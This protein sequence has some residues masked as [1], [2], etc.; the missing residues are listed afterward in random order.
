MNIKKAKE[1]IKN[2]MTAY[3]TKDELGN[4]VIPIERQRPVFLVGPPGIGKTAIME[5]IASELGVGLLSYSMTHHTR[6]SAIGLPFI[7]HKEYAGREYSITEYT[8]SEIIASVYDLMENSGVREGI[9]FLDEI[10]C[11]SETLSPL[12]LQFLQ[13]KV[14]GR[15]RVPEGWIVVTAGN[16]SE[17]NDSVREFD[18]VTLDRLKKI[19]VEPDLEVWKEYA[20]QV[21]IHPAVLTF[22]DIKKS[23][24]YSIETTIDGKSLVTPR[25]W[26]DLSRILLLFEQNNLKVD[27]DLVIQYLQNRKIAKEFA[28]YYELF[29]KYKEDYM[30]DKILDGGAETKI[31]ERA[32]EA[33]FDERLS[34]VG[35]M[36]DCVHEDLRNVIE[37]EDLLRACVERIKQFRETS[38]AE[39][40]DPKDEMDKMI[41][42]EEKDLEATRVSGALSQ[43]ERI[44]RQKTIIFLGELAAKIIGEK[45]AEAAF[46]L[47]KEKYNNRVKMLSK[48]A[49]EA[50]KKLTNMFLFSEE[51]FGE[52]QEMLIIVTELT[53][54]YNSARFISEFGCEEYFRHNKELLFYERQQEII[55]K[56]ENLDIS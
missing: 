35:L 23:C 52:G 49:E 1:Q 13:Y 47:V 4:Y 56:I 9:L 25:G 53:A 37:E 41:A 34:L 28:V 29:I 38:K 6:Q 42:Q 14:F 45:D 8:M 27:E 46:K 39:K 19:E 43:T 36:L 5:Q 51:A 26:E 48:Q 31:K 32:K 7:S 55:T 2:A 20:T 11:V 3:F 24:F 18:V 21:G 44:R 16:P 54:N 22:L 33:Q 30:V 10:N 17:Y 12:M 15:H 40:A 50:K